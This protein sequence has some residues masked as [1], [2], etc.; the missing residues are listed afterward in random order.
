MFTED[1]YNAIF[2][3]SDFSGLASSQAKAKKDKEDEDK[4]KAFVSSGDADADTSWLQEDAGAGKTYQ[5]LIDE[6]NSNTDL[7]KRKNYRQMIEDQLQSEDA[8]DRLVA[9]RLK[10]KIGKNA[11]ENI[12]DFTEESNKAFFGGITK[13]LAGT[14]NW[15]GSGFNGEEADKRTADFMKSIGQEDERGLSALESYGMTDEQKDIEQR[16]NESDA[17]SNA[18]RVAGQSQKVATDIATMLIPG[19]A[20]EKALRGTRAL[21]GLSKMGTAGKIGSS[22]AANVGSGAVATAVGAVQDGRNNLNPEDAGVNTA[23]DAT[24]GVAAPIAGKLWRSLRAAKNSKELTKILSESDEITGTARQ[25]LDELAKSGAGKKDFQAQVARILDEDASIRAVDP[26]NDIVRAAKEIDLTDPNISEADK[27][28]AMAEGNDTT[29]ANSIEAVPQAQKQLPATSESSKDLQSQLDELYGGNYGD[30]LFDVTRSDG[31][32]YSAE[33]AQRAA[34]RQLALLDNE[35]KQ[36]VRQFDGQDI[37][38]N[39]LQ[40]INE[41][42]DEMTALKNGDSAALSNIFGEG[43]SR[44]VNAERLRERIRDLTGRRNIARDQEIADETFR[45]ENAFTGSGRSTEDIAKDL[46]NAKSG[47]PSDDVLV[48]GP[49]FKTV[50]DVADNIPQLQGRVDELLARKQA[51]ESQLENV[52]TAD[53]AQSVKGKIDAKYDS[54]RAQLEGMSP[55]RAKYEMKK[56]D[57]AHIDELSRV[58][59]DLA[60]D[61]EKAAPLEKELKAIQNEENE[62]VLRANFVKSNNPERF[63]VVDPQRQADKIVN[64]EKEK[65]LSEQF[66]DTDETSS[67]MANT[68]ARVDSPKQFE[69]RLNADDAVK[70]AAD[71]K[72]ESAQSLSFKS[73]RP[74]MNFL[75][76]PLEVLRK[77]GPRG[78]A[79]ADEILDAHLKY[80]SARG[81]FVDKMKDWSDVLK[82]TGKNADTNVFRYLDGEDVKLSMPEQRVADEIRTYLDEKAV[83]LGLTDET[84]LQNYIPH[85]FEQSFGK[86]YNE[87][88]KIAAK[89]RY[90][91]D[92]AGKKIAKAEQDALAKSISDVDAESLAFIRA[93]NS[94]KVK[95]GFLQK[96]DGADGFSQDLFKVLS[97]YDNIANKKIHY[98]PALRFANGAS[99]GMNREFQEYLVRFMDKIKG[100]QS[101]LFE[102]TL[103]RFVGE[104]NTAKV[105]SGQRRLSNASIMGASPLTWVKNLQD[106]SKVFADRDLDEVV[107]SIPFALKAMKYGTPENRLLFKHG[108][109]E[110]N[111]ASFLKGM[112]LDQA[113]TKSGKAKNAALKTEQ[114][115]WSGMRATD[116]FTRALNYN[117][118]IG[119]FAKKNPTFPDLL[120][121]G[122]DGLSAADKKIYDEGLS[123]LQKAN[124][125]TVFTFSDVDIPVA[126]NNAIGRSTLNMQTYNL[127]TAKYIMKKFGDVLEKTDGGYR[128]SPKGVAKLGKYVAAN[129]VF[130]AT[131]GAALGLKPEEMLP[132][133]NEIA[134]GQLPQSPL[135]SQLVGNNYQKGLLTTS[136]SVVSELVKSARGEDNNLEG[137][138]GDSGEAWV[139]FAK[140]H[141]PGQTQFNRTTK[142]LESV[143]SGQAKSNS[144]N[145]QF[146][147]DQDP[148][149]AIMATVFGK[150]TTDAG[151]QWKAD[152]SRTLSPEQM[153]LGTQTADGVDID[154]LS[155][156]DKAMYVDFYNYTN[157]A[158]PYNFDTRKDLRTKTSSG[159]KE[160]VANGNVNGAYREVKEYNDKVAKQMREFIKQYGENLPEGLLRQMQSQFIDF[161]DIVPEDE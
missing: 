13:G 70:K 50:Q 52:L 97:S 84:K 65:V 114:A 29:G 64:L 150:N 3:K 47:A 78:E 36:L 131:I 156:E 77:A 106:M 17:A 66:P 33:D 98:E 148:L 1:D 146:N 53:K 124:R 16:Y 135:V 4:L 68:L 155:P 117:A 110:S 59:E 116:A 152:G 57:E 142:G 44:Q 93:N 85:M 87:L 137:A 100:N 122:A 138:L 118:A 72:I 83:Q 79:I 151:K 45:A 161:N 95:N 37:P 76:A 102:H 101:S 149:N 145:I 134:D 67:V 71:Q 49:D 39:A 27:L 107:K 42:E 136:G 157:K 30:D 40:R 19:V 9:E 43:T 80:S 55:T 88:E 23:I 91:V 119:E 89:I 99:E 58:D 92:E 133:G 10:A 24:L 56:I 130:M 69:T 153:R 61:A 128:L 11:W 139:N 109:M 73:V 7:T 90:G 147:Q 105:L 94:W 143:I 75:G 112:S 127:Q 111:Q 12:S 25:Q 20:A 62:L 48:D 60:T 18:G 6:Y 8:A 113:T 154:Q 26:S 125:D 41:L 21:Q 81:M 144:G 158:N 34:Q 35:H 54:Q 2:G 129:A 74:G 115:L 159:A 28:K 108:I 123:Y 38:E 5:E 132:F 46:D 120:A 96:R 86:N 14:V 141:I 63:R 126:L 31:A 82:K 15:I 121:R 140:S 32:V 51:V 22:V 104:G 103:D 160:K